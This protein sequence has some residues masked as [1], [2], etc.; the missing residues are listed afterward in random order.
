MWLARGVARIP[1]GNDQ[2]PSINAK[3]CFGPRIETFINS[4]DH[5]IIRFTLVVRVNEVEGNPVFW[6]IVS[7]V[8]RN[9]YFRK[10]VEL[11]VKLE[12]L[13]VGARNHVPVGFQNRV[14]DMISPSARFINSSSKKAL[15]VLPVELACVSM[16]VDAKRWL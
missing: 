6:H 13:V 14:I 4:H 15:M 5:R 16:S 7:V 10:G 11:F 9:I 1:A 12:A 3:I 2:F 8:L